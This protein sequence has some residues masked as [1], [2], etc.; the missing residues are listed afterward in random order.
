M[1]GRDYMRTVGRQDVVTRFRQ[2]DAA[3][4]SPAEPPA[5]AAMNGPHIVP[6]LAANAARTAPHKKA[7]EVRK[8]SG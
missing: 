4:T 2:R 1:G 3:R 8:I 7:T 5:A 6:S